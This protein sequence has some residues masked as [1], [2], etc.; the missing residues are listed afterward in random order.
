MVKNLKTI[1]VACAGRGTRMEELTKNTPKPL[2][3][4]HSK[5][6]IYFLLKNIKQAGYERI[7]LVVGYKKEKFFDFQE[8][9]SNEFKLEIVDQG[10]V[11]QK[12]GTAIPIIAVE[13]IIKN[14]QFVYAMGD[15]LYGVNDL[16]TAAGLRENTAFVT[17]GDTSRYGTFISDE[18]GML[19]GMKGKNEEPKIGVINSALYVFNP[20]IFEISRQI[21]LSPK[22]EYRITDALLQ[23]AKE[24]KVKLE[25]CQDIWLDFG[26]PEDIKIVENFLNHAEEK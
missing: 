10:L 17:S 23:L 1:I 19:C 13:K 25:T 20:E 4:V 18:T 21:P 12:Y 15:N 6:F 16:V 14:E 5:P 2:I 9:Y 8:K 7:I 11:G 22:G 24:K 3:E 26:R